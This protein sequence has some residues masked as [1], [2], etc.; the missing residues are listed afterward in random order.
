MT[1]QPVSPGP[2]LCVS[3][4]GDPG[5][6]LQVVRLRGLSRQQL[7]DRLTWLSWYRLAVYTAVMDYMDFCDSLAA[8]TNPDTGESE[9]P[10]PASF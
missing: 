7:E 9:D 10:E 5:D 8:D 2:A 3:A 4:V 6:D 1:V